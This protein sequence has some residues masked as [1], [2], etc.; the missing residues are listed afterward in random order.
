MIEIG[1]NLKEVLDGV[2]VIVLLSIGCFTFYKITTP[3]K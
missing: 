3:P 2:I 1:T